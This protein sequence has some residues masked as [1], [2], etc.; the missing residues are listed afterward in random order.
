MSRLINRRRLL[1]G[2]GATLSVAFLPGCASFPVIPKR[3]APDARTGMSWISHRSGM[4]LLTVPRVEMGQNITTALR[5][6]AC[7]ELGVGPE[8]LQVRLHATHTIERVRATV[9][10]ESIMD[11]ALPLARACAA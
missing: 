4:Y 11:Y 2:S 8:K 5:Q 3:P 1:I 10:S 9:G 6:I 7:D